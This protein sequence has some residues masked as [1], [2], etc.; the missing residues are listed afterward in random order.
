MTLFLVLWLACGVIAAM[1]GSR[2]G[3]GCGGFIVGILLGP[4][5]IV[6]ALMSSGNRRACPHCREMI[7]K[8]ASVCPRCQKEVPVIAPRQSWGGLGP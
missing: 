5:G 6:A 4:F 8:Q 2:K 3:E 1:I 7:H